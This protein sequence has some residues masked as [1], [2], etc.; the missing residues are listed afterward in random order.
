MDN[1]TGAAAADGAA[2]TT[3]ERLDTR[4]NAYREDLADLR[5]AGRVASRQF[6]PGVERQIG[7]PM[8]PLLSTPSPASR[9]DSQLLF[10]EPVGVFEERDGWAWVQSRVD[11]YV[12]YIRA[13]ALAPGLEMATHRVASVGTFVYPEPDIKAPPR[14]HLSLNAMLSARRSDDRFVETGYGFVVARHAAPIADYA[15]DWVEI[16]ERLTG[17]PYLWGG[18]TRVGLDCS[19]LVQLA[20]HAAGRPCPRDSDMQRAEVGTEV[21]VPADLEGLVRGDLV[22]WRGHV[23]IMTDGVML[24]HAN[25][26]HMLT[27]VEPLHEACARIERLGGGPI[28]TIRRP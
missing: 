9:I 13:D 17:T 27:V 22:F 15:R 12:G 16:A 25:G 20:M 5:L 14:M 6:V 2:P 4:R 7:V 28:T 24:L 1:E 21:M 8:V 19:G 11:A 10:G 26:F 18:R 3:H 23:G